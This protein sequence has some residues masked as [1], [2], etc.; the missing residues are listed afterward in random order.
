M[1]DWSASRAHGKR[2]LEAE[3]NGISRFLFLEDRA[4]FLPNFLMSEKFA[5]IFETVMKF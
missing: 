4:S 1:I 5:N 3:I 2:P